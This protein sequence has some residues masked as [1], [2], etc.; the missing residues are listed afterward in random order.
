MRHVQNLHHSVQLALATCGCR[1]RQ[2]DQ[3]TEFAI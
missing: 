1:T 2:R 3:G